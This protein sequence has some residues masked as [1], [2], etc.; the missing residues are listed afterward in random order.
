MFTSDDLPPFS[1]KTAR[2]AADVFSLAVLLS[3][4]FIEVGQPGK[5]SLP[6]RLQAARFFKMVRKLPIELQMVMCNPVVESGKDIILIKNSEES[7][8]RWAGVFVREE[9]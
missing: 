9:M 3:D 4:G 5:V 8:R 7:F 2:T 6:S 1:W